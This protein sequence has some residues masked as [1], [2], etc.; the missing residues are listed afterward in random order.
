MDQTFQQHNVEWTNEKVGRFWDYCVSAKALANLSFSRLNGGA[1]V[2]LAQ[3]FLTRDGKNLDY[4]CGGGYLMESLLKKGFHCQGMDLSPES[5]RVAAERLSSY[6]RFEGI[7]PLSD[8]SNNLIPDNTYD[9]VFSIEVVEHLL[10]ETRAAILRN[11]HRIVKVGGY[12]LI[13][14]PNNE[15]LSKQSVL[16]PDCGAIFHD[17]QHVFRYTEEGLGDL[18]AAIGFDKVLSLETCLPKYRNLYR[19]FRIAY[20]SLEARLRGKRAERPHLVYIGRKHA[21]AG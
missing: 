19:R 10:P 7:L 21:S 14:T 18:M 16:C 6:K 8:A 9:F 2:K 20:S 17:T 4:G 15:D 11:L 3:P 12:L 1:L 5:N 13:S